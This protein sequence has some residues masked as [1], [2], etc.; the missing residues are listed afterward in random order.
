[1]P[2]VD[3]FPTASEYQQMIFRVMTPF[4]LAK[5]APLD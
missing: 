2:W 5:H 3:Y 4:S 1:M